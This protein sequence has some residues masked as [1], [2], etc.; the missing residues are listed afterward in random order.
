MSCKYELLIQ[1]DDEDILSFYKK[2]IA[3][4]NNNYVIH[5]D[6]G[7]DL[8]CP[9]NV[10]HEGSKLINLGIKCAMYRVFDSG[11]HYIKEPCGYYL[12]PRSSIY[13]TSYRLANNVGIIDSGYRGNLGAAMDYWPGHK[14]KFILVEGKR[15]WQICTPDLSPLSKITLVNTL[16]KTKRGSGGHGSTGQ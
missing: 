15:Y 13:K 9:Q 7:F 1:I 5:K 10:F 3:N 6:S 8:F 4:Y 12:Y 2:K 11:D 16:D 14:E